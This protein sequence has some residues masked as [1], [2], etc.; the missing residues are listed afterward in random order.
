MS[1]KT[2]FWKNT[3]IED[4]YTVTFKGIRFTF[5]ARTKEELDRIVKEIKDNG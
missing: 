4:I 3:K 1:D 2:D 5:V